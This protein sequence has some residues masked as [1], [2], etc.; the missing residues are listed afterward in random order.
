MA[1]EEK[2]LMDELDALSRELI[3]MVRPKKNPTVEP[4]MVI[5]AHTV[6]RTWVKDK[7]EIMK[8]IE[9]SKPPEGK[10][11][12]YQKE[13]KGSGVSVGERDYADLTR[14]ESYAG[15]PS[16]IT[17]RF[18]SSAEDLAANTGHHKLRAGSQRIGLPGDGG[19]IPA[20]E[21]DSDGTDDA[22]DRD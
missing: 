18:R 22:E 11:D 12:D 5:K 2:S 8:D 21:P 7:H 9:Q 6:I 19:G 1:K 14:V 20:G 15:L 17:D 13:L 16:S 3:A 4:E 10:I